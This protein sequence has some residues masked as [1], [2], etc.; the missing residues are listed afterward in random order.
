MKILQR[1]LYIVLVLTLAACATP[2]TED[3]NKA[4]DAVTK[5]ENDADA[6]AYAPNILVRARDA[7]TRMQTE[8]NAKR[9]DAAKNF[10]NEAISN[11]EQ[12]I[13]DG[14]AAAD[15]ARDEAAN[16]VNGLQAP[17][18][19]TADALDSAKQVDNIKLDFNTLSDDLNSARQTYDSAQQSLAAAN[20]Q[21]AVTKGQN[22]RSMLSDINSKINSAAQDTSRKK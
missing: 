17:L 21:D 7:L 4:Q 11:A 14:K 6:V 19:Q 18:A 3:M 5:A 2:P 20:Y 15:R 1:V 12:A 9:Y 16:L 8:A 22:V 10:A 13:A